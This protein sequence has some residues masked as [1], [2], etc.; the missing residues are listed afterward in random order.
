MA[1]D[2]PNSTEGHSTIMTY[3]YIRHA[4]GPALKKQAESYNNVR[5]GS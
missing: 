3:S 2:T 4:V 5:P 1:C